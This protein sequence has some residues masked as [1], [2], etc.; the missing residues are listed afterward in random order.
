MKRRACPYCQGGKVCPCNSLRA[1]YPEVA[2]QWDHSRNEVGPDEIASR[3]SRAVWRRAAD[4]SGVYVWKATV[5]SR[6]R[7]YKTSKRLSKPR[8]RLVEG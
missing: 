7:V 4:E 6:T 8:R 2:S 5:Y 1:K 3:S